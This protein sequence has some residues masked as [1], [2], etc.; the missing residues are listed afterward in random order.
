MRTLH[1]AAA[2]ADWNGRRAVAAVLRWDGEDESK[3][4]VR[5]LEPHDSTPAGYRALVLGLWEARRAGAK[6]VDLAL[7][8]PEVVA[9]VEGTEQP[10]ADVIGP[11]LQ[12]RALLN[13]FHQARIRHLP[14]SSMARAARAASVAVRPR[15]R[16]A[17]L[18][19]WAAAR[20]TE[21]A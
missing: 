17:D 11:Y 5:C 8:A 10:S 4:I 12:V 1:V 3:T 6:L 18:P 20:R 7:D 19:L 21:A 2:S 15:P 14:P 9:Q 13:V 16:Y